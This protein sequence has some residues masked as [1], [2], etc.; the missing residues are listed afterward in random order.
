[1]SS[2]GRAAGVGTPVIDGLIA[3]TS[4]MLGRDFRAEGRNLD[5]LG[6]AGKSV[7]EI[8]AI[9]ESGVPA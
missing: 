7:A 6:L 8:R 3:L 1:M 2:L 4:A 5:A 9:V